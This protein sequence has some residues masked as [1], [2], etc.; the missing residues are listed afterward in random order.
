MNWWVRRCSIFIV[1]FDHVVQAVPVEKPA[2]GARTRA[3]AP[4]AD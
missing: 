1:A 4:H 2:R 3:A